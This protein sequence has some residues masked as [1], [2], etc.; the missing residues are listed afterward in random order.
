M[1]VACIQQM[2]MCRDNVLS[3]LDSLNPFVFS[4]FLFYKYDL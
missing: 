4:E 1:S 2:S 3:Y